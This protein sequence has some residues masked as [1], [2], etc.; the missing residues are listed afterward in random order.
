M[1]GCDSR[2][3]A[4]ASRSKRPPDHPLA[5][6]DL[7]R[8]LAVEPLVVAHPHHSK[9]PRAQAAEQ[10]V[11]LQHQRCLRRVIGGAPRLGGGPARL[12]GTRAIGSR[13]LAR[14]HGGLFHAE[15]RVPAPAE[16]SL[17][18][19]FERR[20]SSPRLQ[21]CW[22]TCVSGRRRRSYLAFPIPARSENGC[23]SSTRRTSLPQRRELP[24]VADALP[25]AVADPQ[26]ARGRSRRAV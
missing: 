22:R 5:R 1:P 25:G 19:P 17:T 12:R 18:C 20:L 4:R 11:A 7:D 9:R 6:K 3:A 13:Q 26:A 8:H 24:R 21:A 10:T 16:R 15:G 2:A 23:R 14:A